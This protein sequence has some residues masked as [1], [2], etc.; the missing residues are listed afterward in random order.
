MNVNWVEGRALC[1]I[2]SGVAPQFSLQRAPSRSCGSLARRD[3]RSD[4]PLGMCGACLQ[5]RGAEQRVV[6]CP[7]VNA[8]C[9]LSHP[10]GY[11]GFFCRKGR[12]ECRA[13]DAPF[14]LCGF[15]RRK[16]RIARQVERRSLR[17]ARPALVAER[18]RASCGGLTPC[19]CGVYFVAPPGCAGCFW[20]KRRADCRA[21]DARFG[22]CGF[23]WRKGRIAKQVERRTLRV[24]RL[25]FVLA[26]IQVALRV[27]HSFRCAAFHS[28]LTCARVCFMEP[29]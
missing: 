3:R 6:F 5:L 12:A 10:S 29:P 24:V 13:R 14:R 8:G 22:L 20:R 26:L 23:D 25:L 4:A 17:D 11:A 16:S 19:C 2:T 27:T 21:S 9:I 7:L 15:L 28:V 1:G 18:C